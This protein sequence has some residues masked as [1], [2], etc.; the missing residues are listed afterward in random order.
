MIPN[1][2][3]LN[4]FE[5]HFDPELK[6]F[7][8][9]LYDFYTSKVEQLGPKRVTDINAPCFIFFSDP[10]YIKQFDL[11]DTFLIQFSGPVIEME[12]K[13]PQ[14][15]EAFQISSVDEWE[16]LSNMIM[17]S[18][19]LWVNHKCEELYQRA[20]PELKKM[21]SFRYN[22]VDD[23]SEIILLESELM[24]TLSIKELSQTF[25]DSNFAKGHDLAIKKLSE[26]IF[27]T[28]SAK[29]KK[30]KY[31]P[32]YFGKYDDLVLEVE[33]FDPT[34]LGPVF[35]LLFESSFRFYLLEESQSSRLNWEKVFSFIDTPL[36]IIDDSQHLV[37]HNTEFVNLGLSQSK[38][39]ELTDNEQIQIASELF[40]VRKKTITFSDNDLTLINFIPIEE[41]LVMTNTSAEELGIVSSSLAHELNNPLAGIL[42]GL[43][44]LEMDDLDREVAARIKEMKNGVNRCKQ[45]VETFLGFS[46]V[47]SKSP[48]HQSRSI[49]IQRSFDQALEL[50]RFRMIENNLKFSVDYQIQQPFSAPFN[51]S[52]L[53]MLF[54]L[55][56]GEVVTSFSHYSLVAESKLDVIKIKV[57]EN[58]SSLSIK[59]DDGFSISGNFSKSRLIQHLV[60]SQRAKVDFSSG[61]IFS[62]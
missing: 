29:F 18:V 21:V 36:A 14:T 59:W 32:F 2:E 8:R 46:R 50:M 39:L 11:S 53:S 45:L 25:N 15:T 54:Y 7:D 5:C 42:A 23:P 58:T 17:M 37:I 55:I 35:W 52:I 28:E 13:G 60:E 26:V 34:V 56:L 4:Q 27:L 49:P 12:L 10:S 62:F 44:V 30:K 24:K 6:T 31:L 57:K 1:I 9:D 33:T 22:D 3:L 38:C 48:S 16:D 40:R 43:T 20:K 19:D 51:T 41:S 47:G 61:I